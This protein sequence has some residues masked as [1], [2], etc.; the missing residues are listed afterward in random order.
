[1]TMLSAIFEARPSAGRWNS[2]L[3]QVRLLRPELEQM[4]GFIGISLYR[5]LARDGWML[6]LAGFEDERA[7]LRW[8]R[9]S[10]RNEGSANDGG[11]L[12]AER[13]LR[14]GPVA[15]DTGADEGGRIAGRDFEELGASGKSAVT[16]I[17][18]LQ[19][20]DWV[21]SRNPEE[22]ALYLGFDPYSYGDCISWDVLES[23][24]SPGAII[25]VA[26]W[27]GLAPALDF[28]QSAMVPDDA[29][30]RVVGGVREYGAEGLAV[31]SDGAPGDPGP[32]TPQGAAN[33]R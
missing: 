20:P 26:S 10:E 5:S 9:L 4:P 14:V 28:A 32:G 7:M 3:D 30:T 15:F 16:L 29:R 12:L 17:D 21:R 1:M 11:A 6:S 18:G 22:I 23:I 2:Y 13:R 25:L 31:A 27:K 33:D 8:R 24:S 19:W